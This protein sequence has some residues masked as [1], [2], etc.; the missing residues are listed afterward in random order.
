[1]QRALEFLK[2]NNP[3]YGDVVIAI[4]QIPQDLITLQNLSDNSFQ[5]QNIHIEEENLEEDENP[6]DDLRVGSNESML[7]SNIPYAIDEEYIT[8]APGEG[9]K[10][11]SML[12]DKNC[13]ELAFPYLLPKGRFGFNVNR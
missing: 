3:L 10:P 7:V 8:I 1:M 11:L 12:S 13:E 2:A 5:D 4:E 9:K 6:L